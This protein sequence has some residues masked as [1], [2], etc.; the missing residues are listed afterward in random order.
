MQPTLAASALFCFALSTQALTSPGDRDFGSP[1]T[2][3]GTVKFDLYQDYL[4]VARG[5]AGVLRGLTFVID[6]GASRSVLDPRVAQKLHLLSSPASIAVIGGSVQAGFA[7][8]P[9]V[10][11]GPI[12]SENIPI[13]I[14]DLSC[15]HKVLPAPIDGIVGLDVLGQ[16]AFVIDY[17]ARQIHFGGHATLPD[18]VPMRLVHGLAIVDAEVNQM[19]MRMVV[20][21][22]AS[23]LLFFAGNMPGSVK[24]LEVSARQR[25]SNT[26][27]EFARKQLS[28]HSLRLGQAEFRQTLACVVHDP[29]HEGRGFDGLISPVMLGM[30]RVAIDLARGE[31]A[32]SR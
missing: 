29:S 17:G 5:S 27:G 14:E 11:L 2:V 23:S 15:F 31:L 25:P 9:S 24:E 6:T 8:A 28:L 3:E 4:M 22:G 1:P 32:F 26:I 12:T 7:I 13:V 16:S 10:K 18:S 20:D 30:R 19:P 21:T